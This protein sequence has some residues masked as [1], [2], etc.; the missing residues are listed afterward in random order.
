[1]TSLVV[2]GLDCPSPIDKL[3][4]RSSDESDSRARSNTSPEAPLSD[5]SK[6]ER[7][8]I[9]AINEFDSRRSVST[10]SCSSHSAQQ[11]DVGGGEDW[12]WLSTVALQ[13]R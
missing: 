8:E 5:P 13:R 2:I 12:E 10:S 7:V 9:L 1:V 3:G 4:S 6:E 11:A